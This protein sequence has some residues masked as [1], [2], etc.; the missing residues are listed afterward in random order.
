[1]T[2]VTHHSAARNVSKESIVDVGVYG[3]FSPPVQ[4]A[5][6]F[7]ASCEQ[8]GLDLVAFTD[9][10][11]GNLPNEVWAE[12]AAGKYLRRQH[13]YLDASTVMALPAAATSRIEPLSGR[14]D[15]VRNVPSRLAQTFVTL[16][17]AAQGRAWFALGA[18]DQEP[19][20]VRTLADGIRSHPRWLK[21]SANLDRFTKALRG[22]EPGSSAQVWLGG[23]QETT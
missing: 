12:T 19:H 22:V 6:E 1:M 18:S 16:S 23:G 10:I 21:S 13:N 14:I 8:I 15:V 9:Q 17:H 7:S 4:D 2:E 20:R 3:R 5:V 11:A